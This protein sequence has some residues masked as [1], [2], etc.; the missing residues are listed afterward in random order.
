MRYV[1]S[2]KARESIIWNHK[3]RT[4]ERTQGPLYVH[5]GLLHNGGRSL[6]CHFYEEFEVHEMK[7]PRV[8]CPL[9]VALA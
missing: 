6:W 9:T 3:M 4:F 8:L 2:H 7:T 1:L 5:N